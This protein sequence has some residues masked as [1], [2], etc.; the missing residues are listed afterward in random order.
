MTSNLDPGHPLRAQCADAIDRAAGLVAKVSKITPKDDKSSI[1][2]EGSHSGYKRAALAVPKFSGDLRDWNSFWNGFKQAV[3]EATDLSKPA[4]LS[5]L[6]EAMKDKD[7]YRM[8]D[9]YSDAE[10]CY[11][12]AVQ[13]LFDKPRQMHQIY[14]NN[15]INMGPVKCTQKA[16]SDCATLLQESE[17]GLNRLKQSEGKYILTSLAVGHLPDKVR[18]AWEDATDDCRTVPAVKD[19]IDF[20]RK[21]AD[22]PLYGNRDDE[23]SHQSDRRPAK[24][25]GK[26]KGSAH[27]AVSQPAMAPVQSAPLPSAQQRPLSPT[28]SRGSS[29]RPRNS[30]QPVTRYS[31]PLCSEQHYSFSCSAFKKMNMAKRKEHVSTHS[32]CSLCLKPGHVTEE[33]SG[34][35]TCRVCDG[36]HNTLIHSEASP[37]VSGTANLVANNTIGSLGKHKLLMTCEVLAT[38]PTGKSM[39]VRGLLDTGAD[40]SAVTSRVAKH[41]CLEQLDTTIAVSTYGDVVNVP[42][43]S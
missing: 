33:C 2:V 13:E 8:L 18:M 1:K 9:R 29:H 36:S 11:E 24:Q 38:G 14:L 41:L 37:P 30:Q 12:Q 22:N 21:K 34:H 28:S 15:I 26:P 7:I 23:F 10:D 19:L 17:D 6:K 4:K 31:C 32:L 42:L 25:H 43:C 16:L 27:V 3:H 40:I 35:F 39:P 5:Y 20:I